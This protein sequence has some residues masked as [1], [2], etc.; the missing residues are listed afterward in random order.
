MVVLYM[1]V[2]EMFC[3]SQSSEKGGWQCQK[4]D[5]IKDLISY[6]HIIGIETKKG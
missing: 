3:F 1:Q 5:H 2:T 6:D 4:H